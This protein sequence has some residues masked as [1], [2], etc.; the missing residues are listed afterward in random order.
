M[1]NA[2]AKDFAGFCE[3]REPGECLLAEAEE[4][5]TTAPE[6]DRD[7][8]REGGIGTSEAERQIAILLVKGGHLEDAA[9]IAARIADPR[10]QARAIRDMELVH[11]RRDGPSPAKRLDDVDEVIAK[12]GWA[13]AIMAE[14][15][16]E[17][18]AWLAEQGEAESSVVML[19]KAE[20]FAAFIAN[21]NCKGHALAFVATEYMELG[22][23]DRARA[24][25]DTIED[26]FWR[27]AG[28]KNL[29]IFQAEAGDFTVAEQIAA[30]IDPGEVI[31]RVEAYA[32]LAE[33]LAA[34]GKLEEARRVVGQLERQSD[35]AAALGAV[36]VALTKAGRDGAAEVCAEAEALAR[37][38]ED[39]E[40]RALA[41]GGVAVAH[42]KAGNSLA[43]E[44]LTA[45][46]MAFGATPR[47]ISFVWQRIAVALH[48]AG[49]ARA[50]LRYALRAADIAGEIED[51]QDRSERKLDVARLLISL[52]AY[53]EAE[54]V[55]TG[56]DEPSSR[57]FA[58]KDLA[59]A[60][61]RSGADQAGGKD[62]VQRIVAL[63]KDIE[64]GEEWRGSGLMQ[65]AEALADAG[66]VIEAEA[67]VEAIFEPVRRNEAMAGV[68]I[69]LA[70]AGQM[71]E[72]WRILGQVEDPAW[73]A[74]AM[75]A[76]AARL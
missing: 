1:R 41:I 54:Q 24:L 56:I 40:D 26:E 65:V 18:A 48:E 33:H 75:A 73:R 29:A 16:A 17:I 30:S 23:S 6:V 32:L 45:D 28:K 46:L 66:Y 11:L 59:I 63:I 42:V 37:G 31:E 9:R 57:V 38:I 55:A 3:G 22:E 10:D 72:A 36:A 43:A 52:G 74:V 4:L 14:L 7:A 61:V 60:L 13:P 20:Q 64:G 71:V 50:A 67:V 25:V 35:R 21:E 68:A 76:V 2:A 58:L 53:A 34:A 19:E 15:V 44:G 5:L 12:I 8:E 27:A 51:L 49:E 69:A 39:V 70:D 62:N 47:R